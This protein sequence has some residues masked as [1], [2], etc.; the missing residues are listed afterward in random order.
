MTSIKHYL[1]CHRLKGHYSILCLLVLQTSSCITMKHH[2]SFTSWQEPP[3]LCSIYLVSPCEHL[4]QACR[5]N[6]LHPDQAIYIDRLFLQPC[7][8]Q[9]P[10]PFSTHTLHVVSVGL[11]TGDV[12]LI[13]L[14]DRVSN[15][16]I[17]IETYM[18]KL[19]LVHCL[20]SGCLFTKHVNALVSLIII[21]NNNI[22]S[23]EF[24]LVAYF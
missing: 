20:I 13:T 19:L 4:E 9:N 6:Y 2:T 16:I 8:M 23:Q 11:H 10:L 17:T 14:A 3:H 18:H 24:S 7:R 22:L 15:N 5:I 12:L 21:I 1:L